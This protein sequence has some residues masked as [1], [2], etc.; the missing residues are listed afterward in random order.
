[1]VAV[2]FAAFSN[3]GHATEIRGI[4]NK[5]LDVSGGGSGD[6]TPVIIW[7]CHGGRNQQWNITRSGE[8]RGI[9]NKCLDVSGGGS[10]DGTPVVI[11]P[12]HGGANQ[13]W[14]VLTPL[15]SEE[16]IGRKL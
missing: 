6:G 13:K 14:R 11:W 7:P 16:P 10:G 12:C 4:G 3:V 5:C 1:L 9:G 8:I 15:I 2:L